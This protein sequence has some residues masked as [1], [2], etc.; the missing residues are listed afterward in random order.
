M[1]SNHRLS[2][3]YSDVG[4][5]DAQEQLTY[6]GIALTLVSQLTIMIVGS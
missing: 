4:F 6:F 2:K 5:F 1:Q 3:A